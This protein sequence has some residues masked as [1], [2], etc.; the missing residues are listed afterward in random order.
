M[1]NSQCNLWKWF[2]LL[3]HVVHF[4]VTVEFFFHFLSSL[5]LWFS[6]LHLLK[7]LKMAPREFTL[8]ERKFMVEQASRN[9]NLTDIRRRWPFQSDRPSRHAFRNTLNKWNR[10]GSVLP[11]QTKQRPRSVLTQHNL[12]AISLTV[13]GEPT[14]SPRRIALQI[15]ISQG[16]IVTAMQLLDLKPYRP[17]M[18]QELKP[19]DFPR[20]SLVFV[21][22]IYLSLILFQH[23]TFPLQASFLRIMAQETRWRCKC[24]W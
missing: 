7:I 18:V 9:P 15:G 10:T 19:Q 12:N 21:F 11:L 24:S 13:E 20:R 22:L 1:K 6:I 16:S 2:Q 14:K 23:L 17:T 3:S 8:E 4:L 5:S